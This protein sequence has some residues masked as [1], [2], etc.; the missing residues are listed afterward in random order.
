MSGRFKLDSIERF[1]GRQEGASGFGD[2][3]IDSRL[4]MFD[5][6]PMEVFAAN[7]S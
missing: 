4:N 7:L 5:F 3:G 6:F 1:L 2:F